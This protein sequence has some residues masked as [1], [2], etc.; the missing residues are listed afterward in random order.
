MILT[1]LEIKNRLNKDIFIDPFDGKNLNPN[2][3]NLTLA[4]ELMIYLDSQLDMKEKPQTKTLVIP[5]DGFMIKKGTLYLGR[6][7]E[8]T[9]TKN[10]VPIICGRSSIGR[11][12]LA[13]HITAGFGDIGFA[14]YWT[15]EITAVKD[16][17]I[18]PNI[19]I[20]Q[21]I[22]HTIEGN[23]IGYNGKYQNNTGIGA[24]KLEE[25]F[26]I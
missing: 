8:F 20:C 21:V 13:I 9:I 1:G 25:E 14:G 10:L 19:P 6:T 4:P 22:Y 11:L 12:G 24:S 3:Y 15:L 2:S 7:N 16:I 17:V 5:E 26:D 23:Y 18:Y